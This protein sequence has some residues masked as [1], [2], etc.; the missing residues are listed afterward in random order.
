MQ[1]HWYHMHTAQTRTRYTRGFS[2]IEVLV[3]LSIF[4]VV[5]VISIG[6][7][8]VLIEANARAQ[9]TQSVMTNLTFALD[10]ITREIRTGSDY[11]CGDTNDLPAGG[12][13]TA[14]CMNGGAA[15][16]FNEGGQS[17]TE[18]AAT[19]RIAIRVLDGMLQ[20]RLGTGDG[21]GNVNENEDWT[22]ITSP[23]ITIR[24][25]EFFVSGAT[26][27]D[28]NSPTVTIYL[29]GVAGEDDGSQAEFDIQA[30]VVQQLLDI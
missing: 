23:D 30:T 18:N 2:L 24:H 26:R 13:A 17:L 6:A 27:R 5:V 1:H 14:N 19:R 4:T 21:D 11:F 29:E 12:E 8:M 20:R 3:S 28:G 16:S 10:S 25:L 22:P 9:N 7:L 15:L